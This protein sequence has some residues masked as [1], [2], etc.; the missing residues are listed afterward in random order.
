DLAE[1]FGGGSWLLV[2][3]RGAVQLHRLPD[4]AWIRPAVDT[5]TGMFMARDGSEGAAAS[6]LYAELLEP[7]L[8]EL[9]PGIRRLVLVPDDFL[10][11]LPFSALRGE[12]DS[13]PLAERYEIT[14][15]PSAT[16]WLRWRQTRPEPAATPALVFA[17]P[18]TL[19]TLGG[20]AGERS[21]TFL[22]PLRLGKL[23]HARTEGKAVVRHLGGGELLVGEK[24]SETY[25]K[26]T[27][28]GSFGL[29]HFAAHAVTDGVNPDRSG[30]YLSPGD[31]KED[32]VLQS[33]EIAELDLGGRIIVLSTCESALG[34]ILRGEGVM[35][36]ARAFFQAGAHTVV[37]SLWKL[38]DDYGA[39]LFDRFY[40][41]LGEGK[42]VAA[43]LRAAQLDRI[44]DGAPAEAWAGVVVL[45]D[46][47]RVPL[48]GGRP[49]HLLPWAVGLALLALLA[50]FL[51]R[52][53]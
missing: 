26:G 51:V 5:F 34:E 27:G 42:T 12:P 38:R 6:R 9:P 18:V 29:L 14:L 7:A 31:S 19:A 48:P 17:D 3:T 23:P 10:H 46:G 15:T 16:L 20:P 44:E 2:A 52:K 47:D 35:G 36:L 37:A 21:A 33:R 22:G 25:I 53:A 43:A 40:H 41:H 28:A 30:I 4:R 13:E 1:D 8:S 45:G 50:V 24:A 49:R 11:R 39:A 32:G